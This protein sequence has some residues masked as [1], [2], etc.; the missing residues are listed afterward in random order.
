M[1]EW[2]HNCQEYTFQIAFTRNETTTAPMKST[3]TP[4]A[5]TTGTHPLTLRNAIL[6]SAVSS[7]ADHQ[8]LPL[9][10]S[11]ESRAVR[12]TGLLTIL[13]L[14]TKLIDEDEDED[15]CLN[16]TIVASTANRQGRSLQ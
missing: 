5:Q 12:R 10:N 11:S 15:R 7:G 16:A 1:L 4:Q 14:V 8:A 6:Q 13:D 9:P 3:S 2:S